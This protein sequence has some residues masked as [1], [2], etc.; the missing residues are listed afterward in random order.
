MPE[1]AADPSSRP[2]GGTTEVPAP[3]YVRGLPAALRPRDPLFPLAVL[4]VPLPLWWVL[5][6]AN[7][8]WFAISG[9]MLLALVRRRSLPLPKGLGWWMLFCLWLV[10]SLLAL[11]VNP[12]DTRVQSVGDRL[13]PVAFR[14]AEYAAATICLL[15]AYATAVDGGRPA[16]VRMARLF[17]LMLA[18]TV[19]GGVLGVVAPTFELT[20]PVEMLLPR[21]LA[22]AGYV[23]ALVHPASAQIQDVLGSGE[24]NGR[25]S[26]PYPYTN[27]WGNALG[28]LLPWGVAAATLARGRWA[29]LGWAAL[30][31][32]VVPAAV[33]SLNRGLWVGLALAV[34]LALVLLVRRGHVLPAVATVLAGVVALGVLAVS[35]LGSVVTERQSGDAPSNDIRG[36]SMMRAVE[37]AE[38]SPV[39]G[40]GGTRAQMGS[41]QSIAI[42]PTADCPNCGSL[43]IG[44]NGQ[45]WFALTGQGFAGLGLWVV[46]H[47][48]VAWLLWRG[49]RGPGPGSPGRRDPADV[50]VQAAAVTAVMSLWFALVYD[51]TV[52][53]GCLEMLT[54]GVGL[55]ALGLPPLD[56]PS[57]ESTT[58]DGTTPLASTTP[59]AV[60]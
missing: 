53:T 51:R 12:E 8:G 2:P 39:L 36:W 20:S 7:L 46:F 55:A 49:R 45:V 1:T 16:V 47:L 38:G 29:R 13:V 44:T 35:P 31:V 32:A 10:L 21:S 15:W 18:W 59:E 54:L 4:V 9:V 41:L 14:F 42:G 60:R 30:L 58:T 6:L 48:V 19:G 24:G 11:G 56:R 57:P 26:A 34:G 37:L 28:L 25:P 23:S 27:S 22:S 5:G 50:I 40:Y 43:P 33:L 3:R 52:A 17:A